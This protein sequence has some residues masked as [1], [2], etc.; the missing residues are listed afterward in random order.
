MTCTRLTTTEACA[1]VIEMLQGSPE[2]LWAQWRRRLR[3]EEA[4]NIPHRWRVS[5]WLPRVRPEASGRPAN[6]R[7]TPAQNDY[8]PSVANHARQ[9]PQTRLA[10]SFLWLFQFRLERRTNY[11]SSFDVSMPSHHFSLPSPLL[12]LLDLHLSPHVFNNSPAALRVSSSVT[13]QHRRPVHD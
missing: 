8:R 7:P 6:S 3:N 1:I 11:C 12:R 13:P 10:D 4:K 5:P 2:G 9:K